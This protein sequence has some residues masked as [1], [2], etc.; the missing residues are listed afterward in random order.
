M[1]LTNSLHGHGVPLSDGD[2]FLGAGVAGKIAAQNPA[3]PGALQDPAGKAGEKL[4]QGGEQLHH[5][6]EVDGTATMHASDAKLEQTRAKLIKR[7]RAQF[8]PIQTPW[9]APVCQ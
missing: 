6:A 7:Y 1:L 4:L 9:T 3:T 2:F 8:P 5:Q